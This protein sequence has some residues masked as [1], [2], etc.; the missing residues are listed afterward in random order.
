MLYSNWWRLTHWFGS[1]NFSRTSCLLWNKSYSVPISKK[2]KEIYLLSS[3]FFF[4]TFYTNQQGCSR[5]VRKDVFGFHNMTTLIILPPPS[6]GFPMINLLLLIVSFHLDMRLRVTPASESFYPRVVLWSLPLW[7]TL[8]KLLEH[9]Y[10]Q[11]M[12]CIVRNNILATHKSAFI[13]HSMIN[14]LV[15]FVHDLFVPQ[16]SAQLAGSIVGDW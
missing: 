8:S 3:A 14:M 16:H 2:A 9:V 6:F 13:T 11:I 7:C 10:A 5:L 1:K 15:A 4:C 12:H